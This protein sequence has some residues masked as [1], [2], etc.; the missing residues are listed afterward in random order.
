[1]TQIADLPEFD[2]ADYLDNDEAVAQYLRV[3][4]AELC[5]AGE[6]LRTWLDTSLQFVHL[7]FLALLL[8]RSWTRSYLSGFTPPR[9][10]KPKATRYTSGI[11]TRLP[12]IRSNI[13]KLSR[14]FKIPEVPKSM[15]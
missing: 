5:V 15:F 9:R 13:P 2:M 8:R 12:S 11:W 7:A 10:P 1:M 4:L 6:E 3:V 14:S